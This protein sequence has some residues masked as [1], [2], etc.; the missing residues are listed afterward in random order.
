MYFV[1][2]F[3]FFVIAYRHTGYQRRRIGSFRTQSWNRLPQFNKLFLFFVRKLFFYYSEENTRH[4]FSHLIELIQELFD[5]RTAGPG[6]FEHVSKSVNGFCD[7]VNLRTLNCRHNLI[8]TQFLFFYFKGF[9][10]LSKATIIKSVML[11]NQMPWTGVHFKRTERRG[12]R[13][14][15]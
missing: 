7:Y 13:D 12:K 10:S 2:Y 9:T 1:A 4:K 6:L 11:W 5:C 14:L 8:W 15:L 3:P